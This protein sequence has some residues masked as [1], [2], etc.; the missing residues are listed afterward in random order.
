MILR[1]S[2][3]RLRAP[4]TSGGYGNQKRDWAAATSTSYPAAV[5]PVSSA[6]EVVDQ[7]RTATRWRLFL[8]RSADL[9]ASDRI[10]WDGGTYEVE[11]DVERWKRFG[12][13]HHLEAVLFRVTQ[14]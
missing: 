6:E 2:V 8:P 5:Q 3:T 13:L 1:D 14:G 4:L 12:R 11:G 10:E 9:L 7:V